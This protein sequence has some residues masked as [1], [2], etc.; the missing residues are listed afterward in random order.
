MK[1]SRW[2]PYGAWLVLT[3]PLAYAA[4]YDI[5][6][7]DYE[8]KYISPDGDRKRNRDLNVKIREVKDGLNISWV[9]TTLKKNTQKDKKYSIDFL[10]TDRAHIYEAAQKKNLFGGRDPL[11]PIKGEPY[12][13]AR[14]KGRT[15]TTFV[16]T[17]TDDGGYEMQ[18][19]DRSLTEDN[20]L[21]VR[22]SRV[23]N[24][25]LMRTINVTLKRKKP[26]RPETDK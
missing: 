4:D 1:C 9:T 12:A 16:L 15:L 20:N 24:G 19:F 23:R 21:D 6:V 17:I 5:F 22:F 3:L 18:T 10:K 25:D 13:W 2:L 14:I 11:D 8:G 7:G 26:G